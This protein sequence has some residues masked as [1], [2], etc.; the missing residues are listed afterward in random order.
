MIFGVDPSLTNSGW[1]VMD[2]KDGKW[3]IIEA[4]SVK[5]ES[6]KKKMRIYQADDDARRIR[7]IFDELCRVV[8]KY[9]LKVMVAESPSGGG[10]SA[11]AVK[12]MAFATAIIACVASAKGLA[13]VLVTAQ[14]SKK[15]NCGRNNASKDE[16]QR[17]VAELYPDFASQYYSSRSANG[18]SGIFEDIADA[19][20]A[21]HAAER[22]PA[23]MM[24]VQG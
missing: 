7:D 8:D 15:F 18:F 5:T 21:V 3:V 11:K 2:K 17:K 9:D 12:G 4:G 13:L 10:K 1:C 23:V 6:L 14:A 20:C 19:V 22:E 16:M 24:G